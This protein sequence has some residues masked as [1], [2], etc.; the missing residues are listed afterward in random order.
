MH[1]NAILQGE[2]AEKVRILKRNSLLKHGNNEDYILP[3]HIACINPD[4][5]ILQVFF[6]MYPTS[7]QTDSKGRD[8]IH[9]A[10]MNHN[11]DVLELLVGKR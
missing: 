5:T 4:P 7:L 11:P 3:A 1:T 9:Y 10:V 2:E 6:R 8:L